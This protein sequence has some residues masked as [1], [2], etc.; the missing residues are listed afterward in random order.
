MKVGVRSSFVPFKQISKL[1]ELTLCQFHFSSTIRSLFKICSKISNKKFNF[2]AVAITK[3]KKHCGSDALSCRMRTEGRPVFE[4]KL[5][6]LSGE[7][8]AHCS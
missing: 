6:I 5:S 4:A 3:R 1:L 2:S 7:K 8:S